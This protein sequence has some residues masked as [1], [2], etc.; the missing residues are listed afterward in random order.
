MTAARPGPE[1]SPERKRG[2]ADQN[3]KRKRGPHSNPNPKRQRGPGSAPAAKALARASGSDGF[4]LPS[5]TRC[6]NHFSARFRGHLG[7]ALA[8]GRDGAD[9]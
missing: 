2:V 4:A 5:T 1:Q 3:P 6:G 7:V 9:L 8:V